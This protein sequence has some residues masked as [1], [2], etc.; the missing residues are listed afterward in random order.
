MSNAKVD[1][2]VVLFL[3]ASAEVNSAQNL[4]I[5]ERDDFFGFSDKSGKPV[6][7][8]RYGAV[9]LFSEGLAPVYEAGRWGFIDSEGKMQIES[10]FWDAD[11]FSDGLA[12]VHK[13][14]WGYIDRTGKV[15]VSPRYLQARQFS[16]GVASVK[17][18]SGWL[19]VDKTGKPVDGLS[20]F[21][22]AKSFSGG[23]AAVQVGDKWRFTTHEGKKKFEL[24]F[25]K[26]SNFSE[27]LAAVQEAKNGKY[28][29]IDSSGTYLIQPVFEDAMPFAEGLAAVRLD[30]RWGYVNKSSE[31]RIP[32]SY[33]FFADE[34]VGGLALVSNPVDGSEMY[35]NRE[36]KP[37]FF[38]SK[39]P[40]QRERG[41]A[42]YAMC[43]LQLSSA[44]SKA[45]VY[46]IPAYI[47]DQGNQNQ[48]PPSQ[49]K[50]PELKAYL[51]EHF[52]FLRGETNLETH[53]IEQNYV[54]L[55]LRGEETQRRRL[56]IRLGNN[57]A[58]VS[59]EHR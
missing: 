6:I 50:E 14:G 41:A 52:E 40:I 2:F 51:K 22:D 5:I 43:S 16:E 37:Q 24:E 17:D 10:D 9:K 26:V 11:S 29:F 56:D 46:L 54:A 39:K 7:P 35:I 4:Y 53:I 49:F 32:N 57:A 36:G 1:L 44:P 45:N 27:G 42:E 30:K 21:G 8:P 25:T 12:A 59:F 33:P 48:P 55:F 23:L 18:P 28:G 19:F 20:G 3:I 15:V 13:G 31:M 58:S 34:F 47:W 38:K